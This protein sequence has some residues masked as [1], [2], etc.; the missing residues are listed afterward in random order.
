LLCGACGRDGRGARARA[1]RGNLE[2]SRDR[3]TRARRNPFA[4]DKA[5]LHHRL[6]DLGHSQIRAVLLM[7]AWT[8]LIA[9]TAV[10]LAFVPVA[11]ALG[12]FAIGLGLLIWAVRRPARAKAPVHR[13]RV[14]TGTDG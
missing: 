7:Y 8:A 2:G 11:A 5:H 4:P 3:R 6:L 1:S 9:G 10:A 14:G 12:G 13:L